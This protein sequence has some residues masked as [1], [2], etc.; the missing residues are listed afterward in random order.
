MSKT[1]NKGTKRRN[2]KEGEANSW[3]GKWPEFWAPELSH[4]DDTSCRYYSEWRQSKLSPLPS[5]SI[6]IYPSNPSLNPLLNSNILTFSLVCIDIELVNEWLHLTN[7]H[8]IHFPGHSM[9]ISEKRWKMIYEEVLLD[10]TLTYQGEMIA[11]MVPEEEWDFKPRHRSYATLSTAY[12]RSKRGL[13]GM[14]R[15]GQYR[16]FSV[17]G[18]KRDVEGEGEGETGGSS[19]KKAKVGGSDLE[20]IA[21]A[22]M[23]ELE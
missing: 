17:L 1:M 8:A 7:E 9:S 5:F 11:K 18:R 3:V 10:E 14:L 16:D 23:A 4:L 19:S 20:E 6:F 22:E 21:E 12:Y 2:V 15:G 13:E